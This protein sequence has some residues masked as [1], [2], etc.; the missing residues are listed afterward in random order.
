MK[1]VSI[2]GSP[3]EN[4]GKKDA[5]AQR[6]QGMVPCVIYG[7]KEQKLFLVEEKQFTKLLYTPEVNYVE[8]DLNGQVTKAIVQDAQF[9]PITDK[10]L[11]VDF[12]E[13]VD[14]KPITIEIPFKVAG[15]SPGVLKGGSLK[16]RVRKIKVRGL[17]ENIP[18]DI[19]ADISN[20]DINQ[21]IKVGDLSVDNLTIVDN[22]NKVIVIVNPT[23][24]A[25]AATEGEGEGE[26]SAEAEA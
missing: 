7:G 26:E 6:R 12:L 15:T 16:K 3:R 19:T 18:E 22:P 4:V 13:V 1:S 25:V 20:L 14:G 24:N 10:L 5:K 8:L 23:R 17:L 21:F 9:H 2:S 11:H